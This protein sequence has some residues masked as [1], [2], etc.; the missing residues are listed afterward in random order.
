M[1]PADAVT[2]W[3][4][5]AEDV[6]RWWPADHTSKFAPVVDK[7]QA[8]SWAG[9]RTTG[10][11]SATHTEAAVYSHPNRL[12]TRTPSTRSR[13]SYRSLMYASRRGKLE[14]G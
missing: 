14:S 5:L 13:S 2:T 4:A 3:K 10:A 11:A 9:W 8:L 12:K 7:V 6:D 1:V